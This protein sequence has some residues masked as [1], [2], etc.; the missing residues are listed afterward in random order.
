[1][2]L[3]LF[4][5]TQVFGKNFQ[6][7]PSPQS[8]IETA[9]VENLN[10]AITK[11]SP[12]GSTTSARAAPSSVHKASKAECIQLRQNAKKLVEEKRNAGDNA[13][14][15]QIAYLVRKEE[16]LVVAGLKCLKDVHASS[17]VAELILEELLSETSD[18]SSEEEINEY[19]KCTI[20]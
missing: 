8:A 10:T 18:D 15:E 16:E 1:M 6:C 12:T 17:L 7:V 3:G 4:V 20:L 9:T 19:I 11:E 2:R 14:E 5:Q 13:T